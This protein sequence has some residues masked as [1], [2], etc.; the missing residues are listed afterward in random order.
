MI[1]VD[2][3][4]N[5]KP[6]N[7]PLNCRTFD[8]ILPHQLLPWLLESRPREQRERM[9]GTPGDIAEYWACTQGQPGHPAAMSG[10][11]TNLTEFIPVGLHGDEFRFTQAGEKLMAVTMNFILAGERLRF[12]L[13]LIRWVSWIQ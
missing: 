7:Y 11:A 13:F 3:G 6:L 8:I 12:P 10:D 4:L 9:I 2:P 5:L 1:S